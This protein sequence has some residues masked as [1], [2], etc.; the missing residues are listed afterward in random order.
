MKK[1]YYR[2][3]RKLNFV[4]SL[5]VIGLIGLFCLLP[6]YWILITSL[7]PL[8]TEFRLPIEYWPS[9][10]TLENYRTVTGE[11]IEFQVPIKN[12]II[13]SGSVTVATLVLSSM[14]AYAIAR[15]RFKYRI[16][17]LLAIQVGS[18]IPA[19]VTIA[20]TF[21]LIRALGLLR[22]LPGIILPHIIYN[23]PICTFLMA[24]Y[25]AHLPFELEDA[26]KLDG[27]TPFRIFWR[28]IMPLSVPGLFSA[29]I[30]AFLSSWGDFIL[31]YTITMGLPSIATVP[32]AILT[33]GRQW[34]SQWAWISAATVLS[35][36]PLI[37][38][39]LLFQRWVI[40]GLTM[41]AVRY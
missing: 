11:A 3:R 26:A 24:S 39:V 35:L 21:V 8:G 29:G 1:F 6:V 37:M 33:L 10:P 2:H 17:S 12:S 27:Y 31:A 14:A 28:I 22:T 20:P 25:F 19:I 41:G 23:I 36:I 13:V 15:L 34:V 32:V 7:K 38:L 18:M 30:L 16:Q 40:R 5:G 9:E 4:L